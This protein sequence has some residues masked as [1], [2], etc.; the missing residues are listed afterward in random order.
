[1]R[2]EIEKNTI[3]K[4]IIIKRMRIKFDIKII[5]NQMLEDE[6]EDKIQ[7][8]KREKKQQS[9]EWGLNLI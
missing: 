6:I 1:L 2:D 4:D 9:Q 5:W 7:L 8:G 3:N